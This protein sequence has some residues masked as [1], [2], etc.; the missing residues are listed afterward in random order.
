MHAVMR[1]FGEN[2]AI[3]I[4]YKCTCLQKGCPLRIAALKEQDS[5]IRALPLLIC[6]LRSQTIATLPRWWSFSKVLWRKLIRITHIC[7]KMGFIIGYARASALT[8]NSTHI[9]LTQLNSC[10]IQP[11]MQ[12]F[13][14]KMRQFAPTPSYSKLETSSLL[15]L[16]E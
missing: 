10:G 13:G 11:G 2:D 6:I 7:T 4:S 1:S 9:T 5:S 8:R 3:R 12:C 15:V 16:N 14:T